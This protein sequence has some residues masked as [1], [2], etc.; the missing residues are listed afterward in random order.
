M[1]RD[2]GIFATG[3]L[4]GVIAV[5]LWDPWLTQEQEQEYLRDMPGGRRV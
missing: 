5:Y 1:L 2:L 4:V 3:F